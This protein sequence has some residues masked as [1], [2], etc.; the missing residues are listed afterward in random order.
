MARNIP[1]V[2]NGETITK[3]YCEV[4]RCDIISAFDSDK[5]DRSN[6][7]NKSKTCQK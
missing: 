2:V 3:N 7:K 6:T 4:L 5:L 1:V